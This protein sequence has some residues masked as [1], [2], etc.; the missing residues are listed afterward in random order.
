MTWYDDAMRTIVDIPASQLESLDRQCHL[1][2]ISRAEA[3]RRALTAHLARQSSRAA[4]SAFGLWR[5]EGVDG[6]EYER[7]VRAEWDNAAPSRG[8]KKTRR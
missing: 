5:N 4:S 1:E 6:L 2:G 7:R 3:V 8:Q